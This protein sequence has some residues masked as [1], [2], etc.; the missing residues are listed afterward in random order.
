[1][2]NRN[3]GFDMEIKIVKKDAGWR[4]Y[5]TPRF[6]IV[7]AKL[8]GIASPA[9]F[10]TEKAVRRYLAESFPEIKIVN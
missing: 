7:N 8:G 2:L 6:V 4:R 10:K 9:T 3:R 1:M 5:K